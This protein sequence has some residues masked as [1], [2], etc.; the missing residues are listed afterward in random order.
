MR[1]GEIGSLRGG[2]LRA[3]VL[4]TLTRPFRG[5]V[6]FFPSMKSLQAS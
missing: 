2:A 4:F 5:R 1:R 6:F 3:T